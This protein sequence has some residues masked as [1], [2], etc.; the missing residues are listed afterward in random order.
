M[1]LS[2]IMPVYNN[3]EFIAEAI[4][5]ILGQSFN[6]FEFIIIND[7]SS[8]NTINIIKEYQARDSRI[9]LINQENKGVAQ[10]LNIGL[11]N[12]KGEYIAR[13]DA[14]D[15][16]L[17]GRFIQQVEFLE[18]NKKIGFIGCSCEISDEDGKFLDFVYIPNNSKKNIFNL[19]KNNIFCHGSMM[20]RRKLLDDVSGYRIFFKYAQDYDLYLRLIENT[21][22]GSVEEFLYRKRAAI[23]SISIQQIGLQSAYAKLA[24]KCQ[25]YRRN[26]RDDFDLLKKSVL[27]K[28]TNNLESHALVVPFMRALYFIKNNKTNEARKILKPCLFPIYFYKFK[29]YCLWILTFIPEFLIDILFKAKI[30]YRRIKM[31]TLL[32]KSRLM[33]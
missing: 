10:S 13:Q 25:E 33:G 7:G 28:Y 23:K 1:K 31:S 5:S 21:S 16:S 2:V 3:Q 27:D 9:V 12:A 29:L 20:F 22:C 4:E 18:K 26:N 32:F 30:N 6:H 24:R 11:S 17:P 19:S 14:D 15:V 8:D